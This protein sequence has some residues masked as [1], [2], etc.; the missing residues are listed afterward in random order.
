MREREDHIGNLAAIA[1]PSLI[2]VGQEDAITP[3]AMSEAM[4]KSLRNS[5]LK[6][7]TGAG[8]MSPMEKP[9][10]VS[11]AIREFAEKLTR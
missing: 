5:T 11:V 4:S 1:V 6:I 7:I 3:P 8:H 2:L 9:D 10:E